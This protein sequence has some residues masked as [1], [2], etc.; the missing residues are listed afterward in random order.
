MIL[1]SAN[2]ANT[3][4]AAGISSS[5]T[6]IALATGTGAL[7]PAPGANQYFTVV[8]NDALT[9]QV[10]EVCWCTARTGDSLTVLRGQEGSAARAWL[11]GDYAYNTQTASSI[12]TARAFSATN[13]PT[14]PFS[15]PAAHQGVAQ[16]C[17][18]TGTITL[19]ATSTIPDGFLCPLVCTSGS[20][21]ITVNT[22]SATV[23]LP[24]GNVTGTFTLSGLQNSI[25]LQWSAATGLWQ[26][27][28]SFAPV[29]SPVLTGTPALNGGAGTARFWAFLTGLASRWWVGVNA[30]AETG[31]N[32]GSNY[33]WQRY[34]DAGTYIDSPLT[35]YRATGIVSFLYPPTVP[36]ATTAG[37]AAGF[38]Q[39]F[40]SALQSW[41]NMTAS[42]AFG[43]TYTNS[44]GRAIM[45]SV[46]G[47]STSVTTSVTGI[48][49]GAPI[50]IGGQ[51]VNSATDWVAFVVPPGA[52][53]SVT[54]IN[55]N[56]STWYELR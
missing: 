55:A 3:T 46:V 18:A 8:L 23:A 11:I 7:F 41:Q 31:S 44:T 36:D 17:G 12:S 20:T 39:V 22:N 40:G 35:G 30:D 10:H 37:Q 25:F 13:V 47:I 26:T 54:A 43:T 45:V 51:S 19:P 42:R 28:A 32:A 38:D 27:V 50:G 29:N 15:I 33:Q 4:L 24:S 9:G 34:S 21:T 16:L 14:L 2:N 56:L 53:Y 6:T 49:G 48:V 5:V 1:L 52:T